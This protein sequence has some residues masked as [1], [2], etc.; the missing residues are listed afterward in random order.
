[1]YMY[2]VFVDLD[3]TVFPDF[4]QV[5]SEIVLLLHDKYVIVPADKAS[6]IIVF[7]CKS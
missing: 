1:M 7:V 5:D 4:I 2:L 3:F 6:N